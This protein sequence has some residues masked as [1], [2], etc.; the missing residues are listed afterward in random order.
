MTIAPP[1]PLPS[2][3]RAVSLAWPA[4]LAAVVTPLLGLVDAGVLAR[5]AGPADI[6]G[7]ALAGAVFSLV[8]WPLGGLRMSAA[9]LSAQAHGAGDEAGLRAHLVKACLICG[10]V[11][12]VLLCLKWPIAALAEAA[13]TAGTEA[14][15]AAAEAMRAY[16]EIRLWGVPAVA[17]LAG[18]LG[19]L[20]GQGRLGLVMAVLVGVTLVNALLD[21]WFVVGLGYGVRGIAYGTLAA[22]VLGGLAALLAVLW[23]LGQRGGLR[24]SWDR[25]RFA[26][27]ARRVVS[28]NADMLVRTVIL[29]LVFAWFVRAGGRFGDVTLAANQVLMNL[30]LLTTLVIDGAAIAAQTLV[31][32]ALGARDRRAERFGAAVA[33]TSK[34][35]ALLAAS[36]FALMLAF[37]ASL[38]R[39][40]VPPGADAGAVYA[41]GRE[42]LP[43]V[44]AAPLVLAASFQLDGIYIGATRGRALRDG[45]VLS[46]LV[47]VAGVLALPPLLANHGLWLAFALFMVAR[48][49][50]LLALWGGFAPL[51]AGGDAASRRVHQGAVSA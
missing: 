24:S 44:V 29:S 50:A 26:E 3:R 27:D 49:A 46:G 31:G 18:L 15:P 10:A 13:M 11:G 48:A 12:L 20:T 36:L 14:S 4:S 40:V 30:V 32:Q 39:A 38:L 2:F 37:G 23:V 35:S 41:A 17:L 45:M 25:S 21:V 8:Y 34:L 47:F 22:E 5:A 28:M 51:V 9:G 33:E 43:W 1:A 42:Y 6:A 19:W 7:V 16:T